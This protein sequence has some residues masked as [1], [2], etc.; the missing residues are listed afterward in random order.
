MWCRLSSS[1]FLLWILCLVLGW[2][3]WVFFVDV[4]NS[5]SQCLTGFALVITSDGLIFYASASIADYLG[6]HQVTSDLLHSHYGTKPTSHLNSVSWEK[7]K[8]VPWLGTQYPHTGSGPN[9]HASYFLLFL[10]CFVPD[11]DSKQTMVAAQ[12]A[13]PPAFYS[14][15]PWEEIGNGSKQ[16][17]LYNA[18][19]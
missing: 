12:H 17:I 6:F 19:P 16:G 7:A 1:V 8:R 18:R 2:I 11:H 10:T 3:C 4:V 13:L 5:G 9:T 14:L 15:I